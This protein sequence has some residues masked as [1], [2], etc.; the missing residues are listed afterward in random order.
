MESLPTWI[1]LGIGLAIFVL[2]VGGT[3]ASVTWH[4]SRIEKAL[5]AHTDKSV[6]ALR[7]HADTEIEKLAKATIAKIDEAVKSFGETIHAIREK[8]NAVEL[9]AAKVYMRRDSVYNVRDELKNEMKELGDR[10]EKR[11]EAFEGRLN[12]KGRS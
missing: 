6:A 2:T 8:I 11:L 5:I 9:D 12:A 7:D 1:Q 3:I 10:L 4:L